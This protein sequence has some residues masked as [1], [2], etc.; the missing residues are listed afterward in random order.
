M[1][2]L[3]QAPAGDR[4]PISKIRCV[5]AEGESTGHMHAVEDNE[6][7]LM[8]IGERMILSLG[9]PATV[10]HQEHGPITLDAGLWE[11]G[12]VQE[13]DYWSKMARTVAD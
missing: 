12:R 13:Y 5:L 10:T 7:E 8:R 2:K 4:K 1:I 3:K 6:A 9:K 11:I